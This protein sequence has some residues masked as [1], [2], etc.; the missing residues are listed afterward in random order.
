MEGREESKDPANMIL[1]AR[2][3][4]NYHDSS[5]GTFDQQL[6]D[7]ALPPNVQ[8]EILEEAAADVWHRPKK[9]DL[10]TVE[11]VK[12]S[13]PSRTL[14]WTAGSIARSEGAAEHP[15]F[16]F[17]IDLD[18][19]VQSMRD[20]EIAKFSASDG[21]SSSFTAKLIEHERVEDLTDCGG[22][23]RRTVLGGRGVQVPRAGTELSLRFTWRVL[24][25]P[26]ESSAA[27]VEEPT[28]GSDATL[29][30]GDIVATVILGVVR[31]KEETGEETE[32]V[33]DGMGPAALAEADRQ[34]AASAWYL[35]RLRRLLLQRSARA[36]V[37]ETRVDESQSVAAGAP[38]FQVLD[39]QGATLAG[40]E[41]PLSAAGAC[42]FIEG[43]REE[44][45]VERDEA[46][47]RMDAG[48]S[49]DAAF[50]LPDASA[51]K[52]LKDM[53]PGS[54]C[55]V[56]CAPKYAFGDN[57]LPAVGIPPGREL[58]MDLSLLKVMPLEDVSLA[59]DG[60]VVKRTETE[61]QG[62]G[63]P[64]DG[65][66]V[67]IDVEAFDGEG[68]PTLL[69]RRRLAFELGS[70][71]FCSAVEETVHTMKKGEL[72]QV[73]C[74]DAD[75]CADKKLELQLGA[76]GKVVLRLELVD[77]KRADLPAME[78][79]KRVELFT[80]RKEAGNKLFKEGSARRA[81]KRYLHASSALSYLEHWK[82]EKAKSEAEAL[83]RLCWLNAANCQL[84][85][86]SWQ[87]VE[88]LCSNVL[89]EEPGN[90]KALF[91]SGTALQELG[92]LRD[93]KSV[94]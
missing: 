47:V 48:C 19:C 78:E 5:L 83:R 26:L 53:R 32:T 72:C 23:T 11:V 29:T 82:D 50:W 4:P 90:V 51:S 2:Q 89:K 52:V 28:A 92:E 43:K 77:F 17:D 60:S 9:G 94:V 56:R 49:C 69:T 75:A 57:G 81:L 39:S 87:Q 46:I 59:R 6:S 3:P 58:E 12:D 35:A 40:G 30:G 71:S 88:S 8:K 67:E 80:R 42:V 44:Y 22:L 54:R 41:K 24:P 93:R 74:S 18:H 63:Q 13:E 86:G 37:V 7:G 14:T 33:S 64:E 76:S 36:G 31:P 38:V 55:L 85:L 25:V 91:R 84:K 65:A 21:P 61:G 16:P 10:V 66:E 73:R 68:G 62:Y 34:E 79:P 1:P 45:V 20:G 27:A 15:C 70:G